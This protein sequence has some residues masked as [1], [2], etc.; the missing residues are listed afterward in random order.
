MAFRST[1][2]NALRDPRRG[3]L[4]RLVVAGVATIALAC[5]VDARAQSHNAQ[6]HSE[7]D[8]KAAR[9]LFSE[10]Y[11]DEQ[12][13]RFP[14]ALEKFQ[15]VARV[16]DSPVVQYRIGSV[17]E[18]MGRLREA[19][20]TFRALSQRPDI[21]K[22][23]KDISDSAGERA[24][25]LDKRIPKISLRTDKEP[26]EGM[27]VTVDTDTVAASTT[28][29]SVEV[30]PGEH[31]VRSTSPGRPDFSTTVKLAEGAEASM[32]LPVD[33]PPPPPP[34]KGEDPPPPPATS[35]TKTLGGVLVGTGAALVV[36]GVIVLFVR[37]G[38]VSD[39]EKLCPN[40]RC[41][42]SDKDAV[43]AD[44]DQAKLFAP[45]GVALI[46]VGAVAAATGVFFI[47][48]PDRPRASQPSTGQV[49]IGSQPTR[50]GAIL[51]ISGS[52]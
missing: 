9:E 43:E 33:A 20:D 44:K 45:L 31:V 47:V 52:F 6:S 11:K 35:S 4:R 24:K 42:L 10:A 28:P 3:G 50:S 40:D 46:G 15:R 41:R 38:A 16:K 12:E 5:A 23:E 51:G 26:P 30:D 36:G 18:S 34:P 39:I 14:A 21:D 13:K 37:E 27:K 8:I 22:K 25:A 17:L 29:T 1:T 19:R 32:V 48:K 2:N 49:R 7:A